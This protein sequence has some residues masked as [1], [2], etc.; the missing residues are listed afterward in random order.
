MAKVGKMSK[1]EQKQA[2]GRGYY[3]QIR[4]WHPDNNCGDKEI[5]KEIILAYKILEDEAL[6]VRYNIESG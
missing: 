4:R 3:T 6:R 5:A 2:I 1:E